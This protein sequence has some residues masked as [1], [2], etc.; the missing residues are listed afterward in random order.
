MAADLSLDL[1]LRV[2]GGALPNADLKNVILRTYVVSRNGEIDLQ[3]SKRIDLT[4]SDPASIK[5]S[6]ELRYTDPGL[7]E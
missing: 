4:S 1:F 3:R 2:A 7:G 5:L 6:G